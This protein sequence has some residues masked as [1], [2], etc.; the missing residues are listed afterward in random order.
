MGKANRGPLGAAMPFWR[1]A[2]LPLIRP[3]HVTISA[4]ITDRSMT[5]AYQACPLR[6]EPPPPMTEGVQLMAEEL[7]AAEQLVVGFSTQRSHSTS[8]ERSCMY[9]RIANPAINRVGMAGGRAHP[10]RRLRT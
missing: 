9:L 7:L 2:A 4:S 5:P 10:Y 8:S 3:H 6:L 1:S